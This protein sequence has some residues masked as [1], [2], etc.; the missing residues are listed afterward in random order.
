MTMKN[1]REGYET[2]LGETSAAHRD[3]VQHPG[4]QHHLL[5]QGRVVQVLRFSSQFVGGPVPCLA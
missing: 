5:A 2:P 1:L 3:H 4:H